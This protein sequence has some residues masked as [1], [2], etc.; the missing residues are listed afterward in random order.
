MLDALYDRKVIC[1]SCEKAFTSKKVRNSKIIIK[2]KDSDF[3][4]YYDGENPYY[5]DVNICPHCGYAFLNSFL[6]VNPER[7]ETLQKEYFSKIGQ[8]NLSGKRTREDAIRCYKLALICASLNEE[9]RTNSAAICMRLAWLYREKDDSEEE[10][11]YLTKALAVYEAIYEY[12]DLERLAL[13]KHRLYYLIGELNGRL[14]RL[15]ETKRWFNLLLFE[16][17]IEPALRNMAR[18]QW[19]GYKLLLEPST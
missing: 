18:E 13:G 8:L 11:K 17:G 15:E 3:C 5:Y 6:P 7:R 2:K 14:G 19:D 12:E 16:K 9:S 10:H 4:H 1:L